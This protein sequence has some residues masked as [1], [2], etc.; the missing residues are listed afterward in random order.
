MRWIGQQVYDLASRFRNDVFLEDVATGTIASGAHLGLDS[1]NKIVKAVDGG[2]D[3]T[4]I[5]AGTGLSGTNL[6]GPIPTL[7]V[8]AAQGGIT[9]L[10]TLT[11][12]TVDNISIDG[13]TITASADL[14]IIATGNDI[15]V[16]TDTFVIGSATSSQPLLELLNTT[17]D[18]K[19]SIL[20][21]T[22]DK[23]AS[24]ANE[25]D[26]GT[27][28]WKGDNDVQQQ[29]LFAKLYAEVSEEADGDEAGSMFLQVASYDGVLT[30]GIHINGLTE[31]DG[32]VDVVIASGAA[33]T[34]TIAGDLVVTSDLTVNGDTVTFQS[35]N[36][37]DP[38]VTIKNTSNAANDM[39]SL[40][41]VKDRGAAPAVGDNL[42]EIYFIGEDSGQNSQEYGRILCETDVVTDGQE[43]GKLK[44]GVANHDGGNGFGLIM[45]GGSVNDE[46]DVTIGL[47]A[48]S[49]V[50]VPGSIAGDVTGDVTGDVSGSSGSCTGEAAT[51]ETIAGLAPNTATTQ[52]TQGSITSCANLV[53][54]GTIGTGVW[55]ATAIASAKMATGTASAQGALELATT[56]EADTGTDT[57]RAVT[58]AGL[59]S[60]V[61][62]RYSY[63]YITLSA[64]AKPTKDGSVNPEWMVP[65]INKG[66]YEEDWNFDTGIT[67]VTTGTTT[68]GFSRYTTVN[69][70]IIPHAGILVGFHG[71]GRNGTAD[72][73]FKAGLFHADNGLGGA[74]ADGSV[75]EGIDYGNNAATNEFSLR[76]VATA[77]E[78]DKSGGT[79][80]TTNHVLT[81]PCQLI[82]N[83]ANLQLQAGDA[84]MPAIM[85]ND[86]GATDEIFVSMTI[87]LKIPLA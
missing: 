74:G 28:F 43:S 52:A 86:T 87:I 38:I 59:K 54:V 5:V 6:T 4:S 42:A 3:L 24:G 22:K 51:V 67:S 61:D 64:S 26:I 45:T 53:T 40:Q 47:G 63:S 10:G 66:I 78:G 76:C 27:I 48:N 33:S 30:N 11:E 17:N 79:D 19:G 73:T 44:L 23:G 9:S 55:N 41:F 8:D 15:A 25:D 75:G 7:S 39:A 2:G 80:G 84:L 60:H 77:S 21:F 31:A 69:S 72:R 65:N 58:P 14:E 16:V 37:D 82:S 83:S 13:D 81:G 12:L 49:V 20:Q 56:G 32:E 34:T 62:T 70:F 50:T 18:N 85:G 1:N 57:A 36:A 71:I 68:Y 29:T 46:V 35:A